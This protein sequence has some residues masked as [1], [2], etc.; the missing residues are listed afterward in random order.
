MSLPLPAA[1]FE[2]PYYTAVFVYSRTAG[3][4]GYTERAEEMAKLVASQPGFLGLDSAYGDD[5]FGALVSYWRDE[6]SIAA[7]HDLARHAVTQADGRDRWYQA[8]TVHVARVERAY[9]WTRPLP[10]D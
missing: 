5:R 7:W 8:Y 6:P 4:N 10:R 2:L 1:P 9:G 3:A